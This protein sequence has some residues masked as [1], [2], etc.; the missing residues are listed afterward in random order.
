[1]RIPADLDRTGLLVVAWTDHFFGDSYVSPRV[2]ANEH[3][4]DIR[5][6]FTRDRSRAAE[7]DALWFH[8]PSLGALPERQPGQKWVLMSME[9]D[10]NYPV[11]KNP[12][13]DARASICR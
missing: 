3:G 5:L 9:S 11:L 1:M 8:A 4:P 2:V 6:D 12:F 13:L 7:A 10:V